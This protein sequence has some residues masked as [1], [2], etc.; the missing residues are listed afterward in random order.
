M[1]MQN[2]SPEDHG[3]E[4]EDYGDEDEDDIEVADQQVQ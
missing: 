2:D 4:M 1:Q 3:E